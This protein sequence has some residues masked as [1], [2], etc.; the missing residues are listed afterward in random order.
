MN[1]PVQVWEAHTGFITDL[2][3]T[4]VDQYRTV[5]LLDVPN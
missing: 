2:A 3:V 1:V 4:A 5:Y